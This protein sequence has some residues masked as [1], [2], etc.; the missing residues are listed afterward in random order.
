MDEPSPCYHMACI[1]PITLVFALPMFVLLTTLM[2]SFS[3][4]ILLATVEFPMFSSKFDS[5]FVHATLPCI[6]TNKC[7]HKQVHEDMGILKEFQDNA[8]TLSHQLH[9]NKLRIH[10]SYPREVVVG[11]Y[12][13]Y[14]I[15]IVLLCFHNLDKPSHN[16]VI[17]WH[18]CIF[19]RRLMFLYKDIQSQLEPLFIWFI[20]WPHLM[21]QIKLM[22]FNAYFE[23]TIEMIVFTN[24]WLSCVNTSFFSILMV[25]TN[26]NIT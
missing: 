9:W 2:S 24:K 10:D 14:K 22:V 3:S 26:A 7:L 5:A 21:D 15:D 23:R 16:D 6:N 12:H 18:I 11:A 13:E 25:Y 20:L 1:R 17:F 8:H 4:W 19:F